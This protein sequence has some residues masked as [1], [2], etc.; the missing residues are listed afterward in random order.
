MCTCLSP[1]TTLISCVRSHRI[2]IN[3]PSIP[4]KHTG[5]GQVTAC[6]SKFLSLGIESQSTRT[7]PFRRSTISLRTT[8]R[9]RLVLLPSLASLHITFTL[10]VRANNKRRT[11]AR[12]FHD[13]DPRYLISDDFDRRPGYNVKFRSQRA[14]QT[15]TGRCSAAANRYVYWL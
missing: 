9:S 14:A 12:R 15:L 5:G 1:R 3:I 6:L 11:R 7:A 8:F 4:T 13:S 2:N 10:C